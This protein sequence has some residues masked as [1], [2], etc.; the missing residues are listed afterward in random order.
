MSAQRP[1]HWVL[2]AA[3]IVAS[4]ADAQVLVGPSSHFG[5]AMFAEPRSSSQLGIHFDRFTR[6]GKETLATGAYDYKP[7]NGIPET[8]GLNF[9]AYS[10][11]R[12]WGNPS[13]AVLY[14]VTTM[15]GYGHNNPTKW[16]QDKIHDSFDPPLKHVPDSGVVR[17]ALDAGMSFDITKWWGPFNGALPLFLGGGAAPSTIYQEAFLH[18]G[19]RH[20]PISINSILYGRFSIMARGGVTGGGSAFNAQYLRPAYAAL[21]YSLAIPSDVVARVLFSPGWAAIVPE[22]EAILSHD[23]GFFESLDGTGLRESF[24][25]M[26]VSWADEWLV[27]ETWN[28]LINNKDKGPTGGLRFYVR[29]RTLNFLNLLP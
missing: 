22:I 2:T 20:A 21:Q 27:V 10:L 12:P 18:A 9:L 11:T 6:F 17:S 14:R 29:P 1:Y 8:I 16:A 7:Y 26:R 24:V 5:A 15:V 3:C 4:S 19:V 23:T 13:H 25:S 28:D